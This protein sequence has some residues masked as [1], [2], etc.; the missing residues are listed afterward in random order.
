MT[1]LVREYV[2]A[3]GRNPFRNWLDELDTV[4]RARIQARLLRFELGNL[5][6]HKEVGG[7][8][9]E[10][11]FDFGPGYRAY[12]G[13]RGR[14]LVLLLTGGDKKSQKTDIKHAK[15]FWKDFLKENGYG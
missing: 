12:F 3:R 10:A 15:A 8:V 5:G 11:R 1:Y 9:W 13:R 7:G 6:D 14:E 4:T 2:D